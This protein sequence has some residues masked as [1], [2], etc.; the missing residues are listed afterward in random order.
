MGWIL[1]GLMVIWDGLDGLDGRTD[2]LITQ[3]VGY[4]VTWEGIGQA[5]ALRGLW[6]ML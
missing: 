2:L 1:D 3:F 5:V 4:G 6:G